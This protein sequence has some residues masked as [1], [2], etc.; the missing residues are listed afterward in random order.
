MPPASRRQCDYPAC[1]SGPPSPN[2]EENPFIT[3]EDL[4]RREDVAQ[5]LDKHVKMA[6][7]L[8][9]RLEENR[10]KSIQAEAAAVQADANK[11]NE[12]TQRILAQTAQ[13]AAQQQSSSSD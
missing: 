13:L 9:I 8:P 5:E 3:S 12:E 7:L 1:R 4:T 10:T 11:I 2:G 6:H